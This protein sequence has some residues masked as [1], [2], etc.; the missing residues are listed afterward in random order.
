MTKKSLI[1]QHIA[2]A[3]PLWADIRTNEQSLGRQ[4]L[5]PVGNTMD[6]MH[7][8]LQRIEDNHYLGRAAVSDIDV[9]HYMTLPDTFDFEKSDG[10]NTEWLFTP[11]T[12]SGLASG[13]YYPVTLSSDNNIENFWYEA[14]PSRVTSNVVASGATLLA[15][16]VVQYSPIPL[17]IPSGIVDVPSKL[18]V[19]M[20]G[21]TAYLYTDDSNQVTRTVVQIDGFTRTG[22]AVTEELYFIHADTLKT[23]NEFQQV[24]EIRGYY[25]PYNTTAQIR[26]DAAG[27]NMTDHPAAYQYAKNEYKEDVLIYW[28]VGSGLLAGQGTLDIRKYDTDEVLNRLGGY[29]EKH[30]YQQFEMLDGSNNFIDAKDM[31][32]EPHSDNL[33][34]VSSG[35]LYLFDADLYY[36]TTTTME[37]RTYDAATVIEPSTFNIIPGDTVSLF[38]VWKRPTSEIS[39]YRI[40]KIKPDGTKL[41]IVDGAEIAYFSNNSSWQAGPIMRDRF[42]QKPDD[43]VLTESG[44]HTYCLEARYVDGTSSLDKKIICVQSKTAQAEFSMGVA[45]GDSTPISGIEID[46]EYKLWVRNTSGYKY[47]IDLHYDNML[48][49]WERKTLYFREPYDQVRVLDY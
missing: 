2:N 30:V 37:G 11:P 13:T 17:I 6:N 18:Y 5:N 9:Y 25:T 42:L 31:A 28:G 40:W 14:I 10:D 49:D 38:Y 43:F 20:S 39:G 29:T 15:S 36:P 34:V 22:A 47:Q 8:Q 26:V 44:D 23:R 33:W 19:S 48:I 35:L 12:V 16:G 3:F 46:S 4:L 27:F 7:D 24:T 45:T 21:G 1:A 41:S 32:I